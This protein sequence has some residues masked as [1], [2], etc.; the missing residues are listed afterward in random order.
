MSEPSPSKMNRTV[1]IN[2]KTVR[3]LFDIYRIE[4]CT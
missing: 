1:S 4:I 3:F 2:R